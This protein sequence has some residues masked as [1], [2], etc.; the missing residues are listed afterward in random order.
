[1]ASNGTNGNLG[2][3]Y[4]FKFFDKDS[5]LW[6]TIGKSGTANINSKELITTIKNNIYEYFPNTLNEYKNGETKGIDVNSVEYGLLFKNNMGEKL[7][8]WLSDQCMYCNGE[9]GWVSYSYRSVEG[10]KCSFSGI[11]DSGVSRSASVGTLPMVRPV[12]TLDASFV[13]S[14]ETGWKIREPIKDESQT[15]TDKPTRED[16]F[17]FDSSTGMITG[18]VKDDTQDFTGVGWHTEEG[19]SGRISSETTIVIPS[20]INGITVKRYFNDSF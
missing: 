8:Y 14:S 1:M 6:K 11:T 2:T 10:E 15:E 18:A 13:G 17:T 3:H 5:K 7:N 4:S 19:K 9:D 20:K 12:I 16:F